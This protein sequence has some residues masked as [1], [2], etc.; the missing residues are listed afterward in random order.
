MDNAEFLDSKNMLKGSVNLAAFTD[1]GTFF[2]RHFHLLNF[3][4]FHT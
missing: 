4:V 1:V 2:F 3:H